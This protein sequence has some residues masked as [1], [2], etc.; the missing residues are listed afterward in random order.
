MLALRAARGRGK[1]RSA[2]AKT[3]CSSHSR[4]VARLRAR[5]WE[6][7]A[8]AERVRW[9]AAKHLPPSAPAPLRGSPWPFMESSSAC[10]AASTLRRCAA[11]LLQHRARSPLV[12]CARF[13]HGWEERCSAVFYLSASGLRMRAH[14]PRIEL[15]VR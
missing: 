10:D 14:A 11:D 1:C 7:Q 5:I 6:E 13:S 8:L 4:A 9:W 2:T 12:T 3:R 15:R